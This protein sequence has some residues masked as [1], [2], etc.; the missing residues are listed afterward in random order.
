MDPAPD[1]AQLHTQGRGDLLVRQTLD[2]AEH[3]RGTELRREGVQRLLDVRV[4]VGVVEV[5]RRGR[6]AAGSRSAASSPSASKRM[7]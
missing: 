7:R 3:H 2:V 5:L 1:R 4:E 6:L